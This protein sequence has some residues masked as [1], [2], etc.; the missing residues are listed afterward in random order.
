MPEQDPPGSSTDAPPGA[1][2]DRRVFW[3]CTSISFGCGAG[4]LVE[5]T[6]GV[7]RVLLPLWV[8]GAL[9]GVVGFYSLY[10]HDKRFMSLL[11][12]RS[13]KAAWAS[14]FGWSMIFKP[15]TGQERTIVG[16]MCW[17]LASVAAV[18]FLIAFVWVLIGGD[19]AFVAR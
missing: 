19:G 18:A 1:Q 13:G 17:A 3:V 15:P 14:A 7:E 6:R 5:V 10:R 8:V 16:W 2:P 4:W 11:L 12:P 9:A